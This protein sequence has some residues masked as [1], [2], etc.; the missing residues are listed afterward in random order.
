METLQVPTGFGE[1]FRLL[2]TLNE[3]SYVWSRGNKLQCDLRG[4]VHSIE[5]EAYFRDG[6]GV[7]Q[8]ELPNASF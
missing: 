7:A 5:T 4:S 3:Y 8:R 6:G 2:K 1:F